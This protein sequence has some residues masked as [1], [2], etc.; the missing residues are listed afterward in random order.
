MKEEL[1]LEKGYKLIT[2]EDSDKNIVRTLFTGSSYQSVTY[3][4]EKKYLLYDKFTN[5]YKLCDTHK[6]NIENCLVLGGGGFSYPKYFISRYKNRYMDVVEIDHYMVEIARK[7]F[8]LDELY[9]KYDKEKSRL[10]IYEEDAFTYIEKCNK[11]YDSILIDLFIDNEPIYSM[12]EKES[13]KNIKKLTKYDTLVVI[14]YIITKED[15]NHSIFNKVISNLKD[16]FKDVGVVALPSYK[17]KNRGNVLILC[18][19]KDIDVKV[20]IEVIVLE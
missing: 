6:E 10:N 18:S 16:S 12:F 7:F 2:F 8:F 11:K 20:D 14:N 5:L 19:D 3:T 17:E 1:E 9:E 4:D 15:K 13:L